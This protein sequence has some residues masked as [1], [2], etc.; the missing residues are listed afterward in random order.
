MI[1]SIASVLQG[2]MRCGGSPTLS[3]VFIGKVKP[4]DLLPH[5]ILSDG[6]TADTLDAGRVLYPFSAIQSIAVVPAE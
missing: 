2:Y 6:F 3:I 1:R 4:V 5:E